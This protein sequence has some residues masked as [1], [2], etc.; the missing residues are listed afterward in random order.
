MSFRA[1]NL[2]FANLEEK[3][4]KQKI[5]EIMLGPT[6][7]QIYEIVDE[8]QSA[9]SEEERSELWDV[10]QAVYRINKA[11]RDAAADKLVIGKMVKLEILTDTGHLTNTFRDCLKEVAEDFHK[12][13]EEIANDEP[14]I[15]GTVI[16]YTR[17]ED[18]KHL[19]EY[20]NKKTKYEQ[21]EY[22]EMVRVVKE[23]LF[24]EIAKG[25]S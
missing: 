15:F 20:L 2:I 6:W 19:D 12:T 23:C 9:M 5:K 24:L 3:L 14:A 13:I 18:F 11:R 16:E 8:M 25:R 1:T 10:A 22:H 17:D 4:E 21:E 7:R